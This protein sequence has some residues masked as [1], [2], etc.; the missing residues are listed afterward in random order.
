MSHALWYEVH[1]LR[2]TEINVPSVAVCV[3]GMETA[4]VLA[5]ETGGFLLCA[6]T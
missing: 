3:V 6:V 2:Y 1:T 4:G 5:M